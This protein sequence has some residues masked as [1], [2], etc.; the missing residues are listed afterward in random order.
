MNKLSVL[1]PTGAI[2][3]TVV[4]LALFVGPAVPPAVGVLPPAKFDVYFLTIGS[5]GNLVAYGS[6]YSVDVVVKIVA[7]L[8]KPYV[9]VQKG[10]D[11]GGLFSK[12]GEF[13]AWGYGGTLY[14]PNLQNVKDLLIQ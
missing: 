13:V 3:V 10:N 12:K 6:S 7:G 11:P 14:V 8:E 1:W 2:V 9:E 4:F 5:R